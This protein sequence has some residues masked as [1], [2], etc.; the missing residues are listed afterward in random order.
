ML[1]KI[2]EASNKTN[3][4]DSVR[5]YTIP[6]DTA[7]PKADVTYNTIGFVGTCCQGWWKYIHY[8]DNEKTG[9]KT[10]HVYFKQL[11]GTGKLTLHNGQGRGK[12]SYT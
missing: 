7:M 5:W 8:L 3:S 6:T 2:Q 12:Q 9:A 11:G 1:R 10:Y 4:T